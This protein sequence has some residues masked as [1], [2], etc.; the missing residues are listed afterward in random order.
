MK[1]FIRKVVRMLFYAIT[2]IAIA[3]WVLS[4]ASLDSESMMPT[5]VCALSSLWLWFAVSILSERGQYK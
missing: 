4:A 5:V 1:R 3:L 2:G